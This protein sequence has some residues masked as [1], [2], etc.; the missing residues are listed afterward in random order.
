MTEKEWWN[1]YAR[2]LADLL[3]REGRDPRTVVRRGADGRPNG[4]LLSG[5]PYSG[6]YMPLPNYPSAV[7]EVDPFPAVEHVFKIWRKLLEDERRRRQK[8]S[9]S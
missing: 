4:L 1:R 5:E 7:A 8:P 2:Y 6:E 3:E 9:G